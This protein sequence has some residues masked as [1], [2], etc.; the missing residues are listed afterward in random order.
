MSINLKRR[1]GMLGVLL[2]MVICFFIYA[3]YM[4]EKVSRM[5]DEA[6][7]LLKDKD[8]SYEKY[9]D[10]IYILSNIGD[11]KDSIEL[12][13]EVKVNIE[14]YDYAKSLLENE[15]YTLAK[16][17]FER[18][19]DFLD[20]EELLKESKYEY[21]IALYNNNE[22]EKAYSIFNELKTIWRVKNMLR[23]LCFL[24]W[25]KRKNKYIEKR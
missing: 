15:E 25:K 14:K 19:G 11:Y 22:Y 17:E 9:T 1:L 10:A 3:F 12:L 7:S 8:T 18:L 2:L 13:N 24:L 23:K 4:K 6:I 5:Y 20:S 21:A 16:D